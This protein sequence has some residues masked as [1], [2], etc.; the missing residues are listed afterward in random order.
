MKSII[1]LALALLFTV[2]TSNAQT[3]QS[4]FGQNS[5]EWSVWYCQLD[6]SYQA[7][8]VVG[9][10]VTHNGQQYKEVGVVLS[11]T[12]NYTMHHVGPKAGLL[13]EDTNAGKTWFYAMTT[14]LMGNPDTI[15]YLV[16]DLSL[17]LGDTFWVFEDYSLDSVSAVVDSVYFVS[18]MKHVRLD[19]QTVA[20]GVTPIFIEGVGTNIGFDWQ[21]ESSP[22]NLCLCLAEY[23]KDGAQTYSGSC[24]GGAGSTND[25]LRESD[26]EVAVAP[27]P[28]ISSSVLTFDNPSRLNATLIVYDAMGKEVLN[29]NTQDAQ[30]HV[31][32]ANLSGV[33]FYTLRLDDGSIARGKLVYPN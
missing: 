20:S 21:H 5:T 7:D 17:A 18:G 8:K 22:Y 19:Y 15:E 3:Y 12:P 27:H 16:M 25:Q 1:L 10:D 24:A 6:Q 13:R 30:F 11:G 26:L 29:S 9:A 33:Y 28:I 4:I 23:S 2:S 31:Y 14:D 32:N